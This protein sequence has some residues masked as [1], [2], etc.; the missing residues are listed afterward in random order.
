MEFEKHR[1]DN[2]CHTAIASCQKMDHPPLGDYPVDANPPGG[3][4]KFYAAMD[5]KNVDSIKANYGTFND[6]SIA[7]GGVSGKAA[8][9]DGTKNGFINYPSL[10][11]LALHQIFRCLFG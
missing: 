6:A 8:Q 1:M 3:P 2:M 11:I 10:T 7:D 9:F 5:E 4:L